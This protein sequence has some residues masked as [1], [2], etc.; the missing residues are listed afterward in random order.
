MAFRPETP[1]LLLA[2][3]SCI[4]WVLKLLSLLSGTMGERWKYRLQSRRAMTD[5]LVTI[6]QH[7]REDNDEVR[8]RCQGLEEYVD[9]LV[10][11]IQDRG[12]RPPTRP[13]YTP[14]TRNRRHDD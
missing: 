1:A 13:A 8:A 3:A 11:F 6:V 10:A 14:P 9:L 2:S 7:L 4:P 5:D 12:L